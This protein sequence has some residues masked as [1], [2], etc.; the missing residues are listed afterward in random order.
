MCLVS[1]L[2]VR[3]CLAV[4]VNPC[5]G[6]GTVQIVLTSEDIDGIIPVQDMISVSSM[7][8]VHIVAVALC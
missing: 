2:L 1:H 7:L 6:L 5:V 4:F 8:I 3:C